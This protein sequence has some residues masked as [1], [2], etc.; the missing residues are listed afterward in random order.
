MSDKYSGEALV[1]SFSGT[2]AHLIIK[3]GPQKGR[4]ECMYSMVSGIQI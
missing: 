3:L 2:Q 1:L 4:D